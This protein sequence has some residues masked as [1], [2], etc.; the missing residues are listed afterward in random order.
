MHAHAP[1]VAL[2]DLAHHRQ[3]DAQAAARPVARGIGAP[4]PREHARA[5]LLGNTHARVGDLDHGVG[6]VAQESH[7]DGAALGRVAGRVRQQVTHR[8]RE[9]V[10]IRVHR[11][12]GLQRILQHVPGR[13]HERARTLDRGTHGSGCI[14]RHDGEL[15]GSGLQPRK[16]H[17]RLR[18]APQ[19][20][21]LVMDEREAFRVGGQ[22]SVLHGLHGRLDRLQRRAELV[23]D[24]GG[25]LLL[26]PSL[27]FHGIG[28]LVERHAEVGHRVA[29]G[30]A[31]TCRAVS[32][33][34]ALGR[35]CDGLDRPHDAARIQH[36]GER[37]QDHS[38]ARGQREPHERDL[39]EPRVTLG[40]YPVT[41]ALRHDRRAHD[42]ITHDD[43][44]RGGDH[45]P[46]VRFLVLGHTAGSDRMRDQLTV[47]IHHL[48]AQVR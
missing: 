21:G 3:A 6:A 28:H 20:H 41:R 40:E 42:L 25:Q 27:G 48:D 29:P 8:L 24:I 2:H 13:L 26:V 11:K 23:G 16:L 31:G 47:G 37:R 32:A 15:R 39:A 35:P 9:A 19:P 30:H 36:A 12:P 17:D 34:D 46:L 44:R 18:E 5:V 4:E 38:N 7:A 14:E 43:V 33:T 45:T 1:A 22:H 10:G